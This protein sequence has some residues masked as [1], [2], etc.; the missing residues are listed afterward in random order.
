MQ[1]K[2]KQP[3]FRREKTPNWGRAGFMLIFCFYDLKNE[4][5]HSARVLVD[6]C[7]RGKPSGNQAWWTAT[8]DNSLLHWTVHLYRAV[9]KCVDRASWASW[10]Y[11]LR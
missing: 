5:M 2:V 1:S 11:E 3:L 6:L 7:L 4:D 8:N 9:S 10:V